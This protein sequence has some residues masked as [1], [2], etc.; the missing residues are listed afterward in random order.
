[1]KKNHMGS[2]F[3]Q[4]LREENLLEVSEATAAKGVIAFQIAQGEMER[5][6]S[7]VGKR[8]KVELV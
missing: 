8:L 7:A 6:A 5:A 3:D 4:F 1:M 2:D